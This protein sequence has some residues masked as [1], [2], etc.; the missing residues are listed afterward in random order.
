[1][2]SF[3]AAVLAIKLKRLDAWNTARVERAAYYSELL[4]NSSYGLPTT[5]S[6]SECVWHCY[7]IETPQR[8]RVRSALDD[9]GIETAV[10]YPVPVHLQKAYA[11]LGYKPADLPV[12]ERL[13]QQCLS[14]PIYPELSKEKIS[15][16]VSVLLDLERQK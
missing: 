13:C 9:A 1:M 11:H 6:D 14:L 5:F 4:K 2:D 16:V 10:H 3:Q 15:R 7:V 12:T 8:D